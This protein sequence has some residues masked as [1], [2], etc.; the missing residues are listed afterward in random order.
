MRYLLECQADGPD[1]KVIRHLVSRFAPE[2][3]MK[4]MLQG[5]KS[6]LVRDCGM[7][8]RQLLE[9]GCNHVMIVWDLI[10]AEWG[11]VEK[12]KN[13]NPCL[14]ED[15][16][17]MYAALE[18]AGVEAGQVSLVAIEY[19]LESW[20]LADKRAIAGFLST[21]MKTTVTEQQAGS[22][23]S[24]KEKKPKDVLSKIFEQRGYRRYKDFDHAFKIAQEVTD[25]DALMR[26]S[27]FRRFWEKVTS[28]Y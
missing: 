9:D 18:T 8:A 23:D 2:I 26:S 15:R 10:P 16:Q 22:H 27:T 3:E 13:R 24:S 11:D 1:E 21:A 14:H 6:N 4:P 17:R 20:L 5:N 19:M 28:A 12:Q 25:L 7:V